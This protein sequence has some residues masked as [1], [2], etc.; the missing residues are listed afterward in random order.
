[1]CNTS[2]LYLAGNRNRCIQK[3]RHPG[4]QSG[5]QNEVSEVLPPQKTAP[6]HPGCRLRPCVTWE[7][8]L[9][10]IYSSFASSK[11]S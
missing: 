11:M 3:M 8:V 4:Y 9:V 2:V 7:D 1:M 6:R 10:W 5:V